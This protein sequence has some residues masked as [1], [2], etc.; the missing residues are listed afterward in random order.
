MWQYAGWKLSV[1]ST[2]SWAFFL[3]AAVML[4]AFGLSREFTNL[5]SDSRL[6]DIFAGDF[7]IIER[8][9]KELKIILGVPVN[10]RTHFAWL[11]VWGFGGLVCLFSTIA[12]YIILGT[13]VAKQFYLWAFF[14]CL[15]LVSRSVFFHV[16]V[17]T[18]G[19][20][21]TVVEQRVTNQGYRVLIRAAI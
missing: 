16:A 2:T 21:Y 12:T 19:R 8:P 14:Q 1:A 7:P 20:P 5:G 9:G 13:G 18:D 15:W 10:V 6:R 11:L 4:Q 17:I 3:L